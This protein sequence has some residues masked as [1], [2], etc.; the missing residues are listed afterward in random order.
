[1]GIVRVDFELLAE[2]LH[3]PEGVHIRHAQERGVQW[4]PQSVD[5]YIEGKDMPEISEGAT[6]PTCEITYSTDDS[7]KI[8]LA[9]ISW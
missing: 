3:L 4:P 7:G 8:F 2:F 9:G 5:L 6:P 1:M